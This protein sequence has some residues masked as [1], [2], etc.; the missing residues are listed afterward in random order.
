[1]PGPSV[2]NVGGFP[3]INNLSA[4]QNY[5]VN[6]DNYEMIVQSLYDSVAY[7]AAGSN[8]LTLFQTPVGA[9]V[10]VI[11]GVAKTPEDTNMQ[12]AGQLPAMQAY[13]VSSIEVDFQP[14]VPA[15]TAALLPAAFGAQAALNMINDVWKF[16]LSGYLN[17]NI[18][19]KSYLLEGPMMK[20]PASNDL[21][22]DAAVADISTTG[23]AMQ[24]RIGYAK[25]VG[26]AYNISPNNL[27][28][29]PN[30]NFNVTLNWATL[31]TL[32]SGAAARCFVRLMGQLLRASQ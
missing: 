12:G 20:F 22:V 18:G 7:P 27:L 28:L 26:P 2:V 32:P 29:I 11:S 8:Q 16:R 5:A 6:I 21:E 24:S 14:V 15:F 17:F 19:S 30:Q 9:G 1:M 10:G 25:A 3:V 31:S 4:A 13:I 23:A